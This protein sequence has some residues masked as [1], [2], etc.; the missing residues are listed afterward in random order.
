MLTSQHIHHPS[1]CSARQHMA[2]ELLQELV[3]RLGELAL[4]TPFE[5]NTTQLPAPWLA[6]IRDDFPMEVL[7]DLQ[8][9]GQ[10]YTLIRSGGIA[11]PGAPLIDHEQG[12]NEQGENEQGENGQGENGQG[13][14]EVHLSP[15][16][17]EIVRLVAKGYPNK[18]IA[19]VLDISPWTVSTNL[20][21]IFAKLAVN[22]RAEMVASALVTGLVD[23]AL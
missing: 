15:R 11:V 23:S 18:T 4:D 10:R 2:T 1:S 22:S 5:T 16:E 8:L 9:R 21:R 17:Q 14:D 12:E 7:F 6:L 20:R 19:G 3:Q 13:E